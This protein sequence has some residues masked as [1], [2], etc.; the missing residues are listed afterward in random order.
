[1]KNK[2][3]DLI[4]IIVCC[5]LVA[6][7]IGFLIW[8]FWPAGNNGNTNGTSTATGT[9]E[10][11]KFE[12]SV[13][14]DENYVFDFENEDLTKYLILGE[15]KGIELKTTETLLTDEEVQEA[16]M[17]YLYEY[18]TVQKLTEG[19]IKAGDKINVDCTLYVD[20][21]IN[22]DYTQ[23]SISITVSGEEDDN[24]S[25]ALIGKKPGATVYV[26]ITKDAAKDFPKAKKI[27]YA[28]K[29]NHITVTT[30]PEL[31]DDFT[32]ENLGYDTFADFLKYF[33]TYANANNAF[34]KDEDLY[35]TFL[36]KILD[37]S[38]IV[39][40][41]EEYYTNM[42]NSQIAYY[43]YY[44]YYYKME[45]EDFIKNIVKTTQEEIEETVKEQIMLNM[46][47]YSIIKAENITAPED[48]I[49]EYTELYAS[50][51]GLTPEKFVETYGE[52]YV[53]EIVLMEKFSEMIIVTPDIEYAPAKSAT[54]TGTAGATATGDVK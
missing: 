18:A 30:Y 51:A 25:I 40:Y 33:T 4:I 27:E 38:E 50:Q 3:S 24:F 45:Y 39:S 49:D 54:A 52:N 44:A 36:G 41:P 12:P 7:C 17:Q 23:N 6:A 32:K 46:V 31:T 5:V 2:K 11:D 8:K 47:V 34:T 43:E 22:N 1:M 48:M 13:T 37:N 42:L 9:K 14:Y 21:A 20:G 19:E 15:Y 16:L 10:K 29:I 35:V 26:D 28:L 53:K